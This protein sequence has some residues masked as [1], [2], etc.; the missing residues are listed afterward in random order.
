MNWYP[1]CAYNPEQKR[2]PHHAR[3]RLRELAAALGFA[4]GAYDL[5]NNEAGIAVVRRNHA[6]SRPSTSRCPRPAWALT[7]AS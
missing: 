3:A 4:P 1:R 7:T 5:R 2:F 6:A